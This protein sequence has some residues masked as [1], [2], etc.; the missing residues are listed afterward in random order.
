MFRC[1]KDFVNIYCTEA[2]VLYVVL[3]LCITY[4]KIFNYIH[5]VCIRNLSYVFRCHLQCVFLLYLL[6]NCINCVRLLYITNG[7]LC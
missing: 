6:I 5:A 4:F 7:V 3:L 1:Q 2:S